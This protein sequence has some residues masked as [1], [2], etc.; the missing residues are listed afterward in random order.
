MPQ[1]LIRKQ[2]ENDWR[3]GYGILDIELD[4]PTDGFASPRMN[5]LQT[6]QENRK[7]RNTGNHHEPLHSDF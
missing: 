7:H 1:M 3:I 4:F 2:R 5:S 6:K